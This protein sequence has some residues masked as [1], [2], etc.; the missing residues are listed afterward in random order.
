VKRRVGTIAI[1]VAVVIVAIV[2]TISVGNWNFV[3]NSGIDLNGW[4]AL[5][6]GVVVTLAL[7]IG[8]MALVFISN[9]R[10]YDEPPDKSD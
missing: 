6:L 2:V 9:R 4:I 3:G 10:G 5:I 8:L 7:G 1:V